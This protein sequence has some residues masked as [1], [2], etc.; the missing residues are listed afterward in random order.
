MTGTAYWVNPTIAKEQIRKIVIEERLFVML[1]QDGRTREI[2]GKSVTNLSDY[3][4]NS[5]P[6]I[7]LVEVPIIVLYKGTYAIKLLRQL[8]PVRFDGTSSCTLARVAIFP[9]L[10]INDFLDN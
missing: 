4:A 8:I 2:A 5:Q 9:K 1:F 3:L 10:W 7:I 6:L